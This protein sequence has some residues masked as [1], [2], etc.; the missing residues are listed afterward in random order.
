MQQATAPA[1][2]SGTADLWPLD[3][4]VMRAAARRLLAE[5]A[6]LPSD[7]ELD[8]LILQLRGHVML[9]IP[10]VEALAARLAENDVPRACALAG[11]GEA[12]TR[13]GLEPRHVLPA[14]IAHAQRLARSVTALCDH[15]ENLCEAQP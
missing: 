2:E 15:Y 13:L 3:V 9:A 14:R 1:P 7:D 11:V 4:T 6:E 5:D 12:R 10:V 8:T